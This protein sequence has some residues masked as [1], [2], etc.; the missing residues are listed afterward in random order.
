M[1]EYKYE[2]RKKKRGMHC[3]S[4]AC[5]L[6]GCGHREPPSKQHKKRIVRRALKSKLLREY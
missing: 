2:M 4:H 1:N 3:L 5:G 6:C